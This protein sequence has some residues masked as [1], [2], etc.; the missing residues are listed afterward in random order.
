MTREPDT[1]AAGAR[2]RRLVRYALVLGV[3]LRIAVYLERALRDPGFNVAALDSDIFLAWAQRIAGGDLIGDKPF[4]LNPLYAY[5]LAP[6]VLVFGSGTLWATRAVQTVLGVAT[7]A[8]VAGA[9]RRLLGDRAG[10]VAAFLAAAYPLLIFYEQ[11]LMIV[12]LAVFL[13]ALLLY[14]LARFAESRR[15]TTA[16]LAGLALG[17]SML[18]RPNVG[19]F[20]LMLPLWL[21]F[22]APAGRSRIRFAVGRTA[23]LAAGAVAVVLPVTIRNYA[24]GRDFVLVTS[25]GGVNLYQANNAG[26]RDTGQM[27]SEELR[28][29]PVLV[30][31]DAQLV[32]EREEGRS[33]KPS[34]VS[35]YWTRRALREMADSPGLTLGFF[36]RKLLLFLYGYEIPSSYHFE[37]EQRGTFSLRLNPLGFWLVSPLA[38]FGI[39]FVLLR[40]R[41]GMPLFLLYLAYAVGLTVFFPLGHYRAPVLPAAFALAAA[42]AVGLF[43]A[44]RDGSRLRRGLL[45]VAAGL[46]L[47]VTNVP[48]LVRTT[49]LGSWV[50]HDEYAVVY[51]YNRGLH[52]LRAGNIEFARESFERVREVAPWAPFADRGMADLADKVG[53]VRAE[54]KYLEAALERGPDHAQT[55]ARLGLARVKLGSYA[56]GLELLEKA[57][58]LGPRDW[59]VFLSLGEAY[60]WVGRFDD[61]LAAYE[62]AV[63]V[64]LPEARAIADQARCLRLK[65]KPREAL[66][67]LERGLRYMPG[68]PRMR[69]ERAWSSIRAGAADPAAV[70][71]DVEAARS[72]GLEIPAEIQS[73]LSGR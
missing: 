4:F 55:L 68:E 28:P 35:A 38:L 43:D 12:S 54:A 62:R 67:R 10:I 39:A 72:A 16:L 2:Y 36:G 71:Q 29:H 52:A 42:G 40:D 56:E 44:F 49:G 61:A 64:G 45:V 14:L 63:S 53:D 58:K 46:A 21:L 20:A 33:L 48:G 18:A 26:T 5:F 57:E 73:W 27:R 7:I 6:I 31:Q 22:L 23:I 11:V 8:L 34:E 66:A 25:S 32:A 59:P 47:L 3:L 69:L 70:R 17:L 15:W 41:R 24:V 51:H 9:S 37:E 60:E 19:L 1:A 13:N 50:A 65:G 30:E